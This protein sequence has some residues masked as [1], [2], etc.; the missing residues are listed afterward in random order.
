MQEK[1]QQLTKQVTADKK[2]LFGS[3]FGVI[4]VV[5]GI[6][7]ASASPKVSTEST[8]NAAASISDVEIAI[9]G[10]TSSVDTSGV[11]NSWPGELISL[12]SI[13]VQPAREGTIASWNVHVG[14]RVAAGEVLGTL[15]VPSAMPDTVAMLADEQKMVSMARVSA[16]AKRVYTKGRILQLEELRANAERSQSASQILLGGSIPIVQTTGGANISMI[17]AKKQTLRA[18]LRGTLATT[19]PML[20]GNGTL[21]ARWTAVALKDPIGAQNVS[22]RDG[23][24]SI[25]FAAITD[26]DT[27]DKLPIASGLAYFDLTIKLADASIPNGSTLTEAGLLELKAMLHKDQELFIMAVDKLRETQ[28]MAVDTEKMSYEQ[29]RMIDNDIAVLRQDLA[30]SEGD[31]ASKEAAYLTVRNGVLGNSSI[32]ATK[33]GTVSSIMKK[34]GEFV[35]P[36]MPV[37]VVTSEKNNEYIVRFRI[38]SNVRKPE[39]GQELHVTRPGFSDAMQ[40]A[41]M[42]GIGNSLD[43]TGSIMADALLLDSVDWPVGISLRV[44][45]LSE[46]ITLEIPFSSVW[47]DAKNTPNIWRVSSAGRI[48]ASQVS[49]GRTLG[50]KVEIYSG[51]H[52]GD[53]YIVKPTS[54]IVED[55]LVADIPSNANEHNETGR[56]SAGDPHAGHG[57]MEM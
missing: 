54:D 1:I 12:G 38:P 13:P 41:K 24:P 30:M 49:L 37:A 26:I 15:S 5:I 10:A 3:L 46:S 45:P 22:L 51:L 8:S 25:L 6:T 57:G 4:V 50:E 44:L 35:G 53:K 28:L 56:S 29:V 31:L 42:V 40:R 32:V 18:M 27:L 2:I 48:Y 20:S 14:Q 52:V 23:F 39:I 17:E 47:W 16:E 19:Y 9:A 33:S 7:V 55:M 43:E 11:E 34:I 21:P 36:G